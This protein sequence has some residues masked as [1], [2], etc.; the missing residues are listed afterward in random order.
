MSQ[1]GGGFRGKFKGGRGRHSPYGRG[2]GGGGYQSYRKVQKNDTPTMSEGPGGA[3]AQGN[4][5]TQH[6]ATNLM[7]KE[8]QTTPRS[9]DTPSHT[10]NTPG[11]TPSS[12]ATG[13]AASG[14]TPTSGGGMAGEGAG[15]EKKYSVKARLFVGN[16]PK[17]TTQ[18]MVRAMFEEFGEVKEVFVQKEKSFGFVRMVSVRITA[19]AHGLDVDLIKWLIHLT[20]DIVHYL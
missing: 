5:T 13:G 4:D 9:N 12:G 3:S 19:H 1:R 17:D 15:R 6:L 11:H 7:V 8:E 2:G 16:L 10:H 18:D 20:I 14:Q